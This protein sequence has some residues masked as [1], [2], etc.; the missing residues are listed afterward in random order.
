MHVNL[1]KDDGPDAEVFEVLVRTA[2]ESRER[3]VIWLSFMV[4]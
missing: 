2:G 4:G 3:T 1:V